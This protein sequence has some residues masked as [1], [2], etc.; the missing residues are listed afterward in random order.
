MKKILI[1]DLDGVLAESK[2]DVS[3]QMAHQIL[4]LAEYYKIAI[5]SGCSWRQMK[6]QCLDKLWIQNDIRMNDIFLLPTSGSQIYDAFGNIIFEDKLKLKDKCLIMNIFEETLLD[7]DYDE[8]YEDIMTCHHGDVEEDRE[9]QI[10]FSLKG[11]EAPLTVKNAFMEEYDD[12]RHQL[13][14]E[15]QHSLDSIDPGKFL[16]RVGGTTSI[17]ITYSNRDK[18]FGVKTILEHLH[19]EKEDALFFGDMLHKGGN[20]YPVKEMGISCTKIKNPVHM[21]Q[22]LYDILKERF[23]D[24]Y[25]DNG[26]WRLGPGS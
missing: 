9:S 18:S 20:D 1:F 22:I 21:S 3:E 4:L 13:A 14:A 24:E 2:Q 12:L 25:I 6:D 15:I 11:Q 19:L 23:E 8:M 16:V 10:T 5:I 7:E 17:D 26:I